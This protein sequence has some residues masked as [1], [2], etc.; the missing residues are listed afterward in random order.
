MIDFE[1]LEVACVLGVVIVFFC[2]LPRWPYESDASPLM[3]CC[4]LD[5]RCMRSGQP[6]L[7]EIHNAEPFSS[8]G[9]PSF[10]ACSYQPSL[11]HP[12]QRRPMRQFQSRLDTLGGLICIRLRILVADQSSP[13][14]YGSRRFRPQLVLLMAGCYYNQTTSCSKLTSTVPNVYS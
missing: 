13:L 9:A 10:H 2:Q 11:W 5:A 14:V 8:G 3:H 6:L 4:L 12:F 7:P 1:S